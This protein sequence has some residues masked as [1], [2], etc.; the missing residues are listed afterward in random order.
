[1]KSGFSIF[2]KLENGESLYIS[3]RRDLKQ[4]EELA[5]KLNECWP[6]E[7]G[8]Q[9]AASAPVYYATPRSRNYQR[10]NLEAWAESS[11]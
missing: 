8:I 6:A 9:E 10:L 11:I 2:R 3:W 7:Y 1:M 4:A 5:R